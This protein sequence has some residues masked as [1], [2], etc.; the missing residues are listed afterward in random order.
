M[1]QSGA[2]SHCKHWRCLHHLAQARLHGH[3]RLLHLPEHLVV[4]H[5]ANGPGLVQYCITSNGGD[6]AIKPRLGSS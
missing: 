4:E 5:G 6:E 1:A 3:L 2:A